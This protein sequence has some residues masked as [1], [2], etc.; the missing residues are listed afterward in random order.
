MDLA[1]EIITIRILNVDNDSSS[2]SHQ[3][4]I[5]R[6]TFKKESYL[7]SDADEEL[8]ILIEFKQIVDLQSITIHSFNQINNNNNDD[9]EIDTSPPKQI[10]IYKINNLNKDFND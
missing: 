8:L 3:E 1:S 4:L 6:H 2:L 5:D 7:L 10:H 9:D